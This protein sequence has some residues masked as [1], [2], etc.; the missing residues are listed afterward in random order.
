MIGAPAKYTNLLR[1]GQGHLE[2]FDL[3]FNVKY[4]FYLYYKINIYLG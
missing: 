3:S 2:E 4:Y 1:L